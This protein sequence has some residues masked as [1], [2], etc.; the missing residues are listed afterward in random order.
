M[1]LDRAGSLKRKREISEDFIDDASDKEDEVRT[2]RTNIPR[3]RARNATREGI[4]LIGDESVQSASL[5]GDNAH[6][7]EEAGIYN[8]SSGLSDIARWLEGHEEPTSRP[9]GP[10]ER[11]AAAPPTVSMSLI[12]SATDGTSSAKRV[13][14]PAVGTATQYAK[15]EI[16]VGD[17]RSDPAVGKLSELKF[18]SNSVARA[19]PVDANATS[20]RDVHY[21]YLACPKMLYESEE[22]E[23]ILK[24]RQEPSAPGKGKSRALEGTYSFHDPVI[25]ATAA[26]SGVPPPAK[27]SSARALETVLPELY[28]DWF[29]S[30]FHAM[31]V[32]AEPENRIAAAG[33]SAIPHPGLSSHGGRRHFATAGMSALH[34][35]QVTTLG[36]SHSVSPSFTPSQEP[37]AHRMSTPATT[38]DAYGYAVIDA[39]LRGLSQDSAPP[40]HFVQAFLNMGVSTEGLLDDFAC[41]SPEHGGW[42]ALKEEL[43]VDQDRRNIAWYLRVAN[44]LKDRAEKVRAA[45]RRRS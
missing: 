40:D 6:P 18:H 45:R 19:L 31:T 13:S 23:A 10:V 37:S 29:D 4:E 27:E 39:F 24:K 22:L 34:N 26:S 43:K 11:P 41:S 35:E 21:D 16:H 1:V 5:R 32:S 30:S 44:A 36:N 28:M 15:R 12:P 14:V 7:T 2:P 3:K 20:A 38:P 8:Q 9:A 17:S 25:P 42:D 33:N